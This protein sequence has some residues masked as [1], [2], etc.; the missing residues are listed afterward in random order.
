MVAA[1]ES[2]ITGPHPLGATL[3]IY[4]D[5]RKDALF[6]GESQSRILVSCA[7]DC[8]K[9][10]VQIAMEH[11]LDIQEIGRVG[12]DRLIV[13]QHID[14]SCS[15]LVEAYRGTLTSLFEQ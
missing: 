6:F 4:D 8:K 5:F 13:D 1:A 12:G 2:C 10:L 9:E 11:E 14:I 7:P 15:T 3:R